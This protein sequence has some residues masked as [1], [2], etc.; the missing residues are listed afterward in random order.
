VSKQTLTKEAIS[1][2][3]RLVREGMRLFADKGYRATTV[4]EIEE[5]A[6]LSPRAGGLYKH[7]A[8]KRDLFEAGIERHGADS[9]RARR[10]VEMLPL[11][12]LRSDLTLAARWILAELAEERDMMLILQRDG[13][14]FPEIQKAALDRV[15]DRGYDSAE[16]MLATWLDLPPADARAI[17]AVLFSSLVNYRVLDVMVGKPPGGVDEESYV[18]AWVDLAEGFIA[19]WREKESAPP[20]GAER[21][22]VA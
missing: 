11:Q 14:D 18:A 1:T 13:R 3:D 21:E 15:I 16:A 12:D 10:V 8:S 2:R 6:G 9:E 20:G 17:S 7:F 19:A 4:G 22:V 5:A